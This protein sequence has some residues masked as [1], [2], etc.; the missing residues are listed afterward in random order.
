VTGVAQTL[1]TGTVTAFSST[2]L[3]TIGVGASRV[4]RI[5]L[6][7]PAGTTNAA[8]QGSSLSLALNVTGVSP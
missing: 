7:Y 1:Y 5:T 6:S 8:L 4:Y 3:G 2:A